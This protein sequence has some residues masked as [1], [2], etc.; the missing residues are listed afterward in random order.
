MITAGR[1]VPKPK[2]SAMTMTDAP[3]AN[4]FLE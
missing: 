3:L 2:R 1:T 4:A